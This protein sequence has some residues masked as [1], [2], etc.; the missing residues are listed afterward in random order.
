MNGYPRQHLCVCLPV[1][2][3]QLFF[4][5]GIVM[6]ACAIALGINYLYHRS[7]GRCTLEALRLLPDAHSDFTSYF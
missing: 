1:A 2:H 7:I 6:V 3:N 5:I 4:L